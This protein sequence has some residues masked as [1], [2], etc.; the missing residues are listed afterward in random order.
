M[1]INSV[2]STS[3]DDPLYYLRNAQQIIQLCL[4]QYSDLLLQD[5]IQSLQ[6][7]L[8]LDTQAQALLIRMVMRK[9]LL[10]RKDKLHYSEVPNLDEA[11]CTL[12]E[13]GYLDHQPNISISSLC[14]LSRREECLKLAL[15]LL[16]ELVLSGSTRKTD[17]V[18]LLVSTLEDDQPKEIHEW[19][20]DS[21]YTIIELCCG[22]LFDRLRLMFFG[23]LYQS[24][25]EF[26]L[27]ELGLQRFERVTLT[28]ESRPFQSRSEVDLYLSLNTLQ[29]RATDGEQID[30]LAQYIPFPVECSWI[31]YRR[32]KV[33]F[34]LGREAER[35][36][37]TDLALQLFQ[38]SQHQEAQLRALRILE[39]T[40]PAT[41]VFTLAKETHSSITKPEIRVGIERILK[42][43]AVKAGAVFQ[44]SE[45]I[46][47][48]I[49]SL[50][51]KKP[52]QGR[53]ERAVIL[54][55]SNQDKQL[56]HVENQL[57][58]GLFA[59]LFW[60]ALF[61]PI[62]GA[63]FNPFQSGPAD[64]YR[65]TFCE[66]RIDLLDQGFDLLKS[67]NYVDVILDRLRQKQGI[68]CSLIHWPSLDRTLVEQ[69]LALI[70]T[71]HLEAVFRH[72]LLDLRNHRR[73]MPD[74]IEL[75]QAT[76]QYRLIEVKGPGDRLQ[77][78][79][80]LWLEVM[81]NNGIPA[82][83]LKVSWTVR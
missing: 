37:Q 19:W 76:G 7:L 22:D 1:N 45:S 77:D 78:H 6:Q 66:E 68:S 35:Q 41:Q 10:F 33:I 61:A 31:D 18:A 12:T 79:Q 81:L 34:Q 5:E 26:V 20:P 60:P 53:V 16:P 50:E 55:L 69:V 42:R 47:I 57:F 67:D 8:S 83:V 36:K 56:F 38:Q 28:P 39:K 51:L 2:T 73:G 74:L 70:P 13:T 71:M 11:I 65:P 75:N 15:H 54:H 9:G 17:I 43:S 40:A 52:E 80:M 27:T 4:E 23:N 21:P 48:P 82:S 44:L 64:L 62:R 58:T 72:L 32:R 24:W 25:S 14:D 63:F 3:L 49:E 30:L 59:L 29:Q 46:K